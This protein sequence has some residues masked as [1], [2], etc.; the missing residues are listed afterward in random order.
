MCKTVFEF[1][2]VILLSG[3]PVCCILSEHAQVCLLN[4]LN[5]AYYLHKKKY[6]VTVLWGHHNRR[7]KIYVIGAPTI[8][9]RHLGMPQ[10]LVE[11][12]RFRWWKHL[13]LNSSSNRLNI[14]WIVYNLTKNSDHAFCGGKHHRLLKIRQVFDNFPWVSTGGR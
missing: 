10:K 8:P 11:S 2:L 6:M 14:T 1:K 9:V 7:S 3:L 13:M 5:I 12:F 4:V